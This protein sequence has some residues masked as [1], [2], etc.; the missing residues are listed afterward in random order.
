MQRQIILASTSPRRKELLKLLKIKFK[1]ADSGYE[2]VLHK[3][4]SHE[5]LVKFL[6]LGKAQAAAKNI[7]ML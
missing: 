5:N 4:L 7:K 1:V 6:A 3:H 2:E